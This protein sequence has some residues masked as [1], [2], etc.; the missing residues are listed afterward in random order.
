MIC[1]AWSPE[2][3][4]RSWLGWIGRPE[5]DEDYFPADDFLRKPVDPAELLEHVRNLLAGT[6][7]GQSR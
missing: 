1:V 3:L 5:Q 6:A 4:S 7:A 2:T